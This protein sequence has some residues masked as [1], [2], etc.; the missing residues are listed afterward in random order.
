MG[1]PAFLS[2]RFTLDR[3]QIYSYSI[4]VST[5]VHLPP[6]LLKSVDERAQ[7]LRL[8][9]NRY[10]IRALEKSIAEETEWSPR[11]LEELDGPEDDDAT[12]QM[13]DEMRNAI[14]ANRTRKAPPEL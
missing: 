1:R 4:H 11:F 8:S 3:I 2:A 12:K 9:R 7:E 13:V 10:I 5:T 14:A 6:G